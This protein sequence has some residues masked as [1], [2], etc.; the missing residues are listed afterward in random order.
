[1]HLALCA[2]RS[3]RL[4]QVVLLAELQDDFHHA[5]GN[6]SAPETCVERSALLGVYVERLGHIRLTQEEQRERCRVIREVLRAWRR[7]DTD[8]HHV[9]LFDLH[10][11]WPVRRYLWS[12]GGDRLPSLAYSVQALANTVHSTSV[13]LHHPNPHA[14]LTAVQRAAWPT[15][16][17]CDIPNT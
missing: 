14:V 7:A 6:T 8:R 16:S 10:A 13:P 4:R 2:Q 11:C 17:R 3:K 9:A 1:M 5:A 15:T 12:G